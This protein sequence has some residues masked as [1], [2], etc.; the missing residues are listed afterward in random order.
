V[1]GNTQR[2][3]LQG[4][5]HQH[6]AFPPKALRRPRLP[7][8]Q[9][10]AGSVVSKFIP[11][12]CMTRLPGHAACPL[13]THARAHTHTHTHTRV[14]TH[15]HTHHI[16]ACMRT[17]THTHTHTH[18]ESHL[19]TLTHTCTCL[20]RSF[21]RT[22]KRRTWTFGQ[23]S[24]G[25]RERANGVN[26]TAHARVADRQQVAPEA[27]LPCQGLVQARANH[28]R[29]SSGAVLGSE[30]VRRQSRRFHE[31][32]YARLVPAGS[33]LMG[34]GCRRTSRPKT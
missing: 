29:P 33:C 5:S 19:H 21:R 26:F 23:S 7:Q 16:H 9:S 31:W 11:P 24:E 2:P 27:A 18:G 8:Q 25:R 3:V 30:C 6:G 32:A 1:G 28:Q 14:R 34:S 12:L 22:L 10:T 15:T 20:L 4:S 17:R 13:D